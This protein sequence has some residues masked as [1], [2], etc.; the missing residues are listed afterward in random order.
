MLNTI[1]GPMGDNSVNVRGTNATGCTEAH[2]S[3]RPLRRET[4]PMT[5]GSGTVP[6]HNLR[7]SHEP[8]PTLPG[9]R[10]CPAFPG[11]RRT[12]SHPGVGSLW[13]VEPHMAGQILRH[14]LDEH[15]LAAML[16]AWA[17]G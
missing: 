15:W 4:C 7:S 11:R 12:P 14:G 17:E 8:S 10:T 2:H 5:P 13:R 1:V 3:V 6:S 9:R 16:F